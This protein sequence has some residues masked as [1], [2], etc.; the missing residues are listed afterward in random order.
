MHDVTAPRLWTP[1]KDTARFL[2][3]KKF[4]AAY[5][6]NLRIGCYANE[7]LSGAVATLSADAPIPEEH[8]Q[9]LASL[10]ACMRTD[11]A[12]EEG[13]RTVPARLPPSR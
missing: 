4:Q 9:A 1:T 2:S 8:A 5:D 3:K 6:K 10:R 12:T 11:D 13:A 7:A